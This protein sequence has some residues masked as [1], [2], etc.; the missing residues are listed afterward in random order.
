MLTGCRWGADDPKTEVPP[1]QPPAVAVSDVSNDPLHLLEQMITA[2][3]TAVSYSDRGTVTLIGK[4][5]VSGAVPAVKN[6]RVVFSKPNELRLEINT[7][8]FA[9]GRETVRAAVLDLPNQILSFP[10]PEEWTLDILF[11][12]RMLDAAMEI[13]IPRTIL[14]F[15]PQLILLFANEPLNTFCPKDAEITLLKPQNIGDHLCDAVQIA[16]P[17]GNRT[18]WIDRDSRILRRFDYQPVGMP[19]PDGFE[20]IDAVR[21]ELTDAQFNEN[22]S[23]DTFQLKL[24]KGAEC[25][26][27]FRPAQTSAQPDQAAQEAHLCQLKAMV[28]SDCYRL[29]PTLPAA[30]AET[31]TVNPPPIT[32]VWSLPLAGAGSAAILPGISPKLLVSC[33]GNS[34]ALADL[35][36]KL[37]QKFKPE[38]M[39]DDDMIAAVSIYPSGGAE[40]ESPAEPPAS[41]YIGILTLNGSALYVYK[42]SSDAPFNEHSRPVLVYK[43]AAEGSRKRSLADFLFYPHKDDDLLLLGLEC[44]EEETADA[45]AAKSEP[46]GQIQMIDLA[47]KERLQWETAGVPDQMEWIFQ[48]KRLFLLTTSHTP[49]QGAVTVWD[50]TQAAERESAAPSKPVKTFAAAAG[51]QVQWFSAESGTVF[52]LLINIT[53]A[54]V[55][56]A[57]WDSEGTERWGYLLPAGKYEY[58]P[59][60]LPEEKYWLIL[61]ADGQI[62][63]FNTAGN[64]IDSFSINKDWTALCALRNGKQTL[65]LI[66]D[67]KSVAAC[68][69]GKILP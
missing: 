58:P 19:V 26:A 56:F 18:L 37:L 65:L 48:E 24:L 31:E 7:G 42:D 33:E 62:T 63:V 4:T 46:S 54:E 27:A 68:R 59:L 25:T 6:C 34:L 35:Q 44:T 12:D 21:V 9:G 11:Q 64:K 14:R 8:L 45:G 20:S 23:E 10:P 1:P 28:R 52:T 61:S 5:T 67:G 47:G 15:P 32:P 30:P 66:S 16:H 17:G 41:R 38:G 36:G 22:F 13:D 40:S 50:M 49:A 51:W 39:R 2:Y 69:T 29:S 43:P 55:R 60:Y 53:T 57:G 3:K